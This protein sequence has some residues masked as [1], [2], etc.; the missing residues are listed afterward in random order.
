MDVRVRR[1]W[2]RADPCA[3]A[4]HRSCDPS[5]QAGVHWPRKDHSHDRDEDG[6]RDRRD[7]EHGEREFDATASSANG[8]D[9]PGSDRKSIRAVWAR[10]TGR[11]EL[12][13][14]TALRAVLGLAEWLA[15]RPAKV[16]S[17]AVL[18]ATPTAPERC[19]NVLLR[20]AISVGPASR[21]HRIVWVVM[22]R[23]GRVIGSSDPVLVHASFPW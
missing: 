3:P 14:R 7:R 19:R 12:R 23:K 18:L 15:T 17:T 8:S 22:T 2:P 11:P 1:G 20:P 21:A 13:A 10:V 16:R 5:A 6:A 9:W 4:D